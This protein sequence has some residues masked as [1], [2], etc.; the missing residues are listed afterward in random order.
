[1]KFQAQRTRTYL[2]ERY[3][4]TSIAVVAAV[5]DPALAF[6]LDARD[7]LFPA[8]PVVAVLTSQPQLWPERVSVVWSGATFG[9][10]AALALNLHPRARQIALVDA[11]HCGVPP[12]MPCT[13]RYARVLR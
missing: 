12:A 9:E 11:A 2:R 7:P 1:M 8:V 13:T 3:A 5:Y 6:L 10:N 4:E